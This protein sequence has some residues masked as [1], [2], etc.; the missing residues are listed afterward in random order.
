M[1]RPVQG[2]LP[3]SQKTE[4]KDDI[5]LDQQSDVIIVLWACCFLPV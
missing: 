3:N 2:E 5:F 1:N 4:G